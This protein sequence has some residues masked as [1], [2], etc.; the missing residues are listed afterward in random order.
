MQGTKRSKMNGVCGHLDAEVFKL[1]D[2]PQPHNLHGVT[3]WRGKLKVVGLLESQRSPCVRMKAW[4][5]TLARF[6]GMNRDSRR[7]SYTHNIMK[8]TRATFLVL[9]IALMTFC[10]N[11]SGAA[12]AGTAFTYQGQLKQ[13][14]LPATGMYDL[15]FSLFTAL[16]GGAPVGSI[17][18]V[19]NVSVVNGL[20]TVQLN[21]AGEFGPNAF[22]GAERFL[23]IEVRTPSGGGAFTALTPRQPITG[24]PFAIGQL[25]ANVKL[26]GAIGDGMTNDTA[27]IQSAIDACASAGGGIV[28][29]PGGRYKT[30]NSLRVKFSN[31]SLMGAGNASVVAPVGNFDTVAFVSDAPAT[32]VYAGRVMD[33]TF[34][35]T[36]KTGGRLMY[37]SYVANFILERV[38]AGG[39]VKGLEFNNFN[40][41]DLHNLRV[42]DYLGGTGAAYLR[43]TGGIAGVGR[44]D[45]ANLFRVVFG[46]TRSLGMRG[47]DVDGFVHT[48]NA[49]AVH[50]VNIGAE[51]LHARNTVGASNGPAFFTFDD[52]EADYP[53]LEC[54]RL[55]VGVRMNFNNVQLNGSKSRAG[56]YINNGVKTSTFTGGFISGSHQA[57]IA[58]A[59]QDVTVNGMQFLFNSSD[60]FGGA[61]GAYPGILVGGTSRGVVISGCRSGDAATSNYQ[62]YGC[63]VDTGAD[64]FVITGN[65]FRNNIFSG[66]NNGAGSGATKL[67]ANNI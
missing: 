8:I 64:D 13:S 1:V 30:T 47:V 43:L 2:Y 39:G 26:Y 61:K 33:L 65:N 32:Y 57:G 50:L 62:S 34:D 16:A 9:A 22:D 52:F 28:W 7:P 3:R 58:I 55:D 17:Q 41:V 36:G 38:H 67:L 37:G 20:F 48:V 63:Q 44:S 24:A 35:E 12:P 6:S 21:G 42:T 19:S 49:W 53:E 45:V 51:G 54:V 60:E 40:N 4:A 29:F 14:G 25:V 11:D 23:Q 31:V 27:A 5:I 15:Q 18:M 59:G 46:G 56:I 66:V 10:V